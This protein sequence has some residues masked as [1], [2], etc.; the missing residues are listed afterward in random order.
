VDFISEEDQQAFEAEEGHFVSGESGK[1]FG[2]KAQSDNGRA[3]DAKDM[4]QPI[5]R[6][7]QQSRSR[8]DVPMPKCSTS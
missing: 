2:D 7:F 4:Q 3:N 6:Y 1:A 8:R 5:I